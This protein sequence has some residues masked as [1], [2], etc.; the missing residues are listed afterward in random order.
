MCLPHQ[1]ADTDK[2]AH[3]AA[4]VRWLI[5]AM[6][7]DKN[8]AHGGVEHEGFL[9]VRTRVLL[10]AA[11]CSVDGGPKV[12]DVEQCAARATAPRLLDAGAVPAEQLHQLAEH[13]RA[14]R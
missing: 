1:L 3:G 8:G 7:C 6:C 14:L 10:E 4:C 2:Q 9:A 12:R 11:E 5:A 13:G